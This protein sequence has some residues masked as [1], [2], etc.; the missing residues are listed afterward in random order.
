MHAK[1]TKAITTD[2]FAFVEQVFNLAQ[3][4][5]SRVDSSCKIFLF[6]STVAFGFHEK[7]SDLDFVALNESD[8]LPGT[9]VDD[10]S[11]VQ[12]AIQSKFVRNVFEELQ[13]DSP[14]WKMEVV[15]RARVPVLRV[16]TGSPIPFDISS[17][18]RN[19]VRNSAL[20]RAYIQQRPVARWLCMLVKK[21]GKEVGLTGAK[22]AGF[23]TS[24]GLNIMV[25]HYLMRRKVLS[26]I[27]PDAINIADVARLPKE[28]PLIPLTDNELADLGELAL[29]FLNFYL[30]EFNP[31]ED[32]I[33]INRGTDRTPRSALQWNTSGAEMGGRQHFLWCIEDPYELNLNVGREITPLKSTILQKHFE[34]AEKTQFQTK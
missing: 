21:W 6:G 8:L 15:L 1:V 26:P 19:G 13:K 32:V 23:L 33:S 17:H 5:V 24:Y 11:E 4:A 16:H 31:A 18:R 22:P 2:S 9:K 34:N 7:G 14:T 10:N 12:R 28:I 25:I 3:N 20:L 30:H 27:A 29:G